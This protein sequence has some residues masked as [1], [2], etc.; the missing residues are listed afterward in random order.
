MHTILRVESLKLSCV[1]FLLKLPCAVFLKVSF[2]H[3]TRLHRGERCNS[4]GDL[5]RL[6]MKLP[7]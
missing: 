6:Q 4:F 2:F 3:T 1:V 7:P 5:H